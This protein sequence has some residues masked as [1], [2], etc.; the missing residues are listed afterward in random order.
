MKIIKIV[1]VIFVLSMIYSAKVRCYPIPPNIQPNLDS[2][3]LKAIKLKQLYILSSTGSSEVSDNYKMQFFDAFP[4]T[5]KQLDELYGDNL[6]AHN[7]PAPLNDRAE[8][9]ILDLFN[10]LNCINDTLYY[11]KIILIANGGHWDGDAINFFQHG[12][13]NKVLNDP[14]LV[15]YIL[16][17][18]PDNRIRSFWFFYFDGVHP[19]EQIPKQLQKIKSINNRIYNLMIEAQTEVLKQY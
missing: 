6:D 5:F 14:G 2:L 3:N 1:T 19:E 7:K 17:D 12:L 4:N 9:H 15:V 18:M 8:Q 11:R 10:H 13:R 16:K